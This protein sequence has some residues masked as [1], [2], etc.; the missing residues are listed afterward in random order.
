MMTTTTNAAVKSKE[1]RELTADEMDAVSGGSRIYRITN[2]R[3]NASG[4]SGG[5]A[6]VTQV[7]AS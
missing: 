3:A 5:S 1:A 2:I 7:I 6:G 4:L